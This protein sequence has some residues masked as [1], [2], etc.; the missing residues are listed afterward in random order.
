ATP[1]ENN[2]AYLF[3]HNSTDSYF[4]RYR[5]TDTVTVGTGLNY[6]APHSATLDI[7]IEGNTSSV[8]LQV[9]SDP[10]YTG[11]A[12]SSGTI[13]ADIWSLGSNRSGTN[14]YNGIIWGTILVAEEPDE[15]KWEIGARQWLSDNA[16]G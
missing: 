12:S 15:T 4:A 10:A 13:N 9:N 3:A 2:T 16:M 1:A 14:L 6:P 5:S 8:E 7:A 11:S